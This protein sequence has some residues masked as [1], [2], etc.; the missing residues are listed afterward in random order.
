M[1]IAF[2]AGVLIGFILAIPPGP[3]AVTAMR[4]SMENSL[5]HGILASL[6]TGLM[7]FIYCL[8]VIFATSAI[9]S[10]VNGFFDDYPIILL[11]FQLFVIASIIIYGIINIKLKDKIANPDNNKKI[12]TERFKTLEKISRKG[13]FLLG[14]AVAATN[15]ANPTFLPA[16]AYVTV[17]VQKFVFPE[18]SALLSVIFSFAFG[19][20][21]FLWLYLISKVLVHYKDR[22]SAQALARVHQFAGFTL[23][24]FGTVLGYRVLTLTHWSEIIRLAI[25]F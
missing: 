14:I 1:I 13:P 19:L 23:I 3:V 16:L 6:G 5:K 7:D 12:N 15:F 18:N 10:F 11:G 22:M 17:N 20:G 2:V 21:N 9:L 25:A 4:L 24:G 8:I